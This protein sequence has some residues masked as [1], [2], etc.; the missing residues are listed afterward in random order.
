MTFNQIDACAKLVQTLA[1]LEIPEEHNS[2][3]DAILQAIED[4]DA[5]YGLIEEARE[6]LKRAK[7]ND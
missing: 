6:I 1:R 3:D 5:L 4:A 2:E 7:A